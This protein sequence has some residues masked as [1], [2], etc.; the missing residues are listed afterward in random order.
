MERITS[1]GGLVL[2]TS[3]S[4]FFPKK[5]KKNRR[6][7]KNNRNRT[8]SVIE[9]YLGRFS[10]FFEGCLALCLRVSPRSDF[11]GNGSYISKPSQWELFKK[12]TTEVHRFGNRRSSISHFWF[13]PRL[14][15]CLILGGDH[16]LRTAGHQSPFHFR[17]LLD[18]LFWFFENHGHTSLRTAGH[19]PTNRFLVWHGWRTVMPYLR[20]PPW[21]PPVIVSTSVPADFA[22]G[23]LGCLTNHGPRIMENRVSIG[24]FDWEPQR[25]NGIQNQWAIKCIQISGKFPNRLFGIDWRTKVGGG[26]GRKLQS[27]HI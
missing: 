26:G 1:V 6:V 20:E 9:G 22:T 17:Q 14:I 5:K 11:S 19:I 8:H 25:A 3:S 18:R 23:C 24:C 21:E 10:E 4:R 7:S 16:S 2:I 12:R 15:R 27:T 13:A